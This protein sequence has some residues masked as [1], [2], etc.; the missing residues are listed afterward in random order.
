MWKSETHHINWAQKLFALRFLRYPN[1]KKNEQL[2]NF[3]NFVLIFNLNLI[4][5]IGDSNEKKYLV[6]CFY[7]HAIIKKIVVEKKIYDFTF[8]HKQYL[9][10]RQREKYTRQVLLKFEWE[11]S[12]MLSVFIVIRS[13]YCEGEVV[14]E[15]IVILTF[16]FSLSCSPFIDGFQQKR[17]T[18]I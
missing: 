1:E 10:S 12:A 16:S 4:S 11:R 5:I 9:A 2:K 8:L 13:L 6:F 3:L 17:N 7:S 14:H 18:E 15:I